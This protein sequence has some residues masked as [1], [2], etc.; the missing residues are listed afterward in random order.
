MKNNMKGWPIQI[1][2]CQWVW[3]NC[4]FRENITPLQSLPATSCWMSLLVVM[5]AQSTESSSRLAVAFV[6]F[7]WADKRILDHRWGVRAHRIQRWWGFSERHPAKPAD[8]RL[9]LHICKLS[10]LPICKYFITYLPF[11]GH[12]CPLVLFSWPS[13]C[14]IEYNTPVHSEMADSNSSLISIFFPYNK[15]N[16]WFSDS[17]MFKEMELTVFK[18]NVQTNIQHWR[19][20]DLPTGGRRRGWQAKGWM[21][22]WECLVKQLKAESSELKC[23]KKY[24]FLFFFLKFEKL[25]KRGNIWQKYFHLWIFWEILTKKKIKRLVCIL[26]S[27]TSIGEPK[28]DY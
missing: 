2:I 27:I 13:S 24:S 4:F 11:I 20:P 10:C 19:K 3:M 21:K 14:E 5:A 18:K 17:R 15:M 23:G 16:G 7:F 12:E 28:K 1:S 8:T 25:K 6:S 9:S 26:E 22:Q